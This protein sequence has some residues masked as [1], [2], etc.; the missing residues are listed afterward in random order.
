MPGTRPR[1]EIASLADLVGAIRLPGGAHQRA[2][3]TSVITDLLALRRREPGRAPDAAAWEK[4]R[5]AELDGVQVPVNEY[6]PDHPDAV[7][8]QMG[9]IPRRLPG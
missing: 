3:G 9:A 1:R 8:G 2:A 4:T 7:L 5:F 6:F